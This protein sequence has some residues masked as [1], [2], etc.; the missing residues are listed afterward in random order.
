MGRT[1]LHVSQPTDAGV[2]AVVRDLARYQSARGTATHVATPGRSALTAALAGS[3]VSLHPWA[4]RRSPGPWTLRETADLARI[5]QRVRPDVVVLHSAKAGLAGR[6]AVRGRRPTV[7][8]PHAWSFEAATGAIR[9]ASVAWERF[10]TRWTDQL[11]C[12]TESECSVGRVHGVRTRDALVVPNGVDTA[13]FVPADRRSARAAL[14]LDDRPLAVCVG[15]LSRQKGQDLLVRAWPAVRR[16]VP[17]AQLVLVGEGP[18][19]ADLTSAAAAVEGVRLVGASDSPAAWYQAADVLVCPSRWEGMA[20][21]PLEAMACGT[22]VVGT[23]V[24]GLAGTVADAGAVVAVGADEDLVVQA[25]VSE[26]AQ[27]LGDLETTRA[28]GLRGRQRVED[29]FEA[30]QALARWDQAI[31]RTAAR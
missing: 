15:R 25:L 28:E 29:C 5:I 23:D 8:V 1:V 24:G 31:Q 14:G 19:E 3:G 6:L 30:G 2:A 7:F 18:S 10:A 13:R 17:A 4:A 21:V 16:R 12:L 20:L 11:V 27:R 26:V 9:S 22:S